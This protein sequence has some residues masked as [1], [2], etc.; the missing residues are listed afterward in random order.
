MDDSSRA[1]AGLAGN[2]LDDLLT[3]SMGQSEEA[4]RSGSIQAVVKHYAG[5]RSAKWSLEKKLTLIQE[6]L[7]NLSKEI[8]PTMF[9]NQNTQSI[10][11][12]GIGTTC[13]STHWSASMPDKEAAMK[14]LRDSG[15][16]GMI[17]DSVH[18]ETLGAFA[19]DRVA[20][21]KPLPPEFFKVT[22]KSYALVPKKA[23]PDTSITK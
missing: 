7:D 3:E 10:N 13:I 21:G 11:I 2:Y 14:W 17:K 18:H 20:E 22:T 4:I 19:K 9:T 15:N 8:L 5:L 23:D 6:H 12:V 1:C 16:G